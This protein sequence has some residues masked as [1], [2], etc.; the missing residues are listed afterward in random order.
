MGC[1]QPAAAASRAATSSIAAWCNQL[2]HAR[3]I[4]CDCLM[5]S[6]CRWEVST[7]DYLMALNTLA[8]RSYNDLNQY[9]VRLFL[10]VGSAPSFAVTVL[11]GRCCRLVTH[12][13]GGSGHSI[14]DSAV[15]WSQV[16]PWVLVD[17]TSD[18]QVPSS[19]YFDP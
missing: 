15:F 16:S 2:H 6:T 4:A 5:F 11:V 17:Y 10:P 3:G 1:S 9:P 12:R 7:F 8:G 14:F 13:P 18:T 19:A